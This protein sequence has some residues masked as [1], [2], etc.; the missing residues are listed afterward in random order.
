MLDAAA[1]HAGDMPKRD[2]L[3]YL[4][5][6]PCHPHIHEAHDKIEAQRDYFGGVAVP[7]GIVCAFIQGPEEHYAQCE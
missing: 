7:W 6:H 2:N 1:P 3:T 5:T 4:C